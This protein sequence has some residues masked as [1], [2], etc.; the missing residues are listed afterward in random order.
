M[1][2]ID[3]FKWFFT[4]NINISSYWTFDF[5]LRTIL[6][7]G[8]RMKRVFVLKNSTREKYKKASLRVTNVWELVLQ[9]DA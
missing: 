2:E 3:F 1:Y 7:L 8:D 6:R 9:Y 5:Y 4:Y